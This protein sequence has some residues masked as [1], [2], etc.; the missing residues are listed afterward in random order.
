[1]WLFYSCIKLKST[2]WTKAKNVDYSKRFHKKED[3]SRATKVASLLSF[4]NCFSAE[5]KFATWTIMASGTDDG[6]MPSSRRWQHRLLGTHPLAH[7]M[8]V[9]ERMS[10]FGFWLQHERGSGNGTRTGTM[11]RPATLDRGKQRRWHG[12]ASVHVS[13]GF[14]HLGNGVNS[15]H[16]DETIVISPL[17]FFAISSFC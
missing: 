8:M 6:H 13:S 12:K 7:S 17:D 9:P 10:A 4:I 16:R 5:R 3:K 11:V 2:A 1:M 14:Q 15:S